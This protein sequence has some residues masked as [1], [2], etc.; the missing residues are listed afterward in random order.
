M[1]K[2]RNGLNVKTL[3]AEARQID[4]KVK[5]VVNVKKR[6]KTRPRPH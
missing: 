5:E 1:S 3:L 2:P 6:D 4:K